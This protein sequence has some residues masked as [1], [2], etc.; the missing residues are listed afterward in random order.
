MVRSVGL[1]LVALLLGGTAAIVCLLFGV[2]HLFS[3]E[4]SALLGG[5]LAC[6]FT[7]IAQQALTRFLIPNWIQFPGW[8]RGVLLLVA[9]GMGVILV[10]RSPFDVSAIGTIG[11]IALVIVG[12]VLTLTV[13]FGV[14]GTETPLYPRFIIVSGA[15]AVLCTGRLVGV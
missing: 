13:L 5:L 6:G 2:Q 7:V 12:G 9:V 11:F 15:V 4:S 3:T 1:W 8:A 10:T 14:V